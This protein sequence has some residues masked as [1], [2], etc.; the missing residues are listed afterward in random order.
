MVTR[1]SR[2]IF[3]ILEVLKT[4]NEAGTRLNDIAQGADL[5]RPTAHRLL[6]ELIALGM[7]EQAD[8]RRYRL[9]RR[10]H[11]LG[12]EAPSF[13]F[14]DP[15]IV[16]IVQR[17]AN[18]SGDTVVLATR[19]FGGVRFLLRCDGD[20]PVRTRSVNV[21]ETR[22][23]YSSYAGIALMAP[24]DDL[25]ISSI[26]NAPAFETNKL[27]AYHDPAELR[28]TIEKCILHTRQHGWFNAAGV[29]TG[30]AGMAALVP[31]SSGPPQLAIVI[32]AVDPRLSFQRAAELA[33]ILLEASTQLSWIVD[34]RSSG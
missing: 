25:A 10:L 8:S 20:F 7:V 1:V 26:L 12:V 27:W 14:D 5:P 22:S 31:T 18:A 11:A 13:R 16:D 33:P 34:D 17:V 2:R 29:I 3:D 19:V 6:S 24:L 21:G 15:R 32:S 9:G 28:R 30:I 23:F 4:S